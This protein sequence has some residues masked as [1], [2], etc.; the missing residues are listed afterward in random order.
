MECANLC[1]GSVTY[2]LRLMET[3]LIYHS[4]LLNLLNFNCQFTSW[5]VAIM[6]VNRHNL[7]L[8]SFANK[9]A[10]SFEKP[11]I[12]SIHISSPMRIDHMWDSMI[13]GGPRIVLVLGSSNNNNN[14]L[15]Y[16]NF[17][18]KFFFTPVCL[19]FFVVLSSPC[20]HVCVQHFESNYSFCE[21]FVNILVVYSL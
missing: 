13:V 16:F 9:V 8:V 10:W 6:K 1:S 7:C 5:N 18:L 21:S 3:L 12:N 20:G 4:I 19:L 14:I 15:W 11:A 17:F 2:Y